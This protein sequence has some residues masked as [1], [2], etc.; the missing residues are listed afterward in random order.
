MAV[1]VFPTSPS[2]GDLYPSAPLAGQNQYVWEATTNTWRLVGVSTGVTPGTYGD[3]ENIPTFT[4]D[5]QGKITFASNNSIGDYYVKTGSTSAYNNYVWP[6]SDGAVNT[7]LTTDGSGNL[8]WTTVPLNNIPCSAITAKGDLITGAVPNVPA[9]LTV[10]SNGQLLTACSACAL[11]I[12]WS[13]P[14]TSSYIP[15]SA[16]F[17]KGSLLA[18]NGPAFPVSLLP[19]V[20][21]QVLVSC[22]GCYAGLTWTD[23]VLVPGNIS[24]S[25]ISGKGAILTGT[26]P[27]QPVALPVGPNGFAL[28]ACSAC[29]TGLNWVLPCQGTMTEIDTGYGLM[30]GPLTT[31]GTISLCAT[32][33]INPNILA[34]KGSLLVATAANTP[35]SL[36]VGTDGQLLTA[37]STNPKGIAWSTVSY[38]YIFCSAITAKGDILTGS[39]PNNPIALSVGSDGYVLRACSACTSGLQWGPVSSLGTAMMVPV[40]SQQIDPGAYGQIAVNSSYIYWY[41]GS[42]WQRAAKD[43]IPW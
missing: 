26:A 17:G 41:D 11:G 32:C 16:I 15:C 7:A 28:Q 12:Y 33:V 21:G 31:T 30:G 43:P 36:P 4:V 5:L 34:G 3:A 19:G 13:T 6:L 18:G 29:S 42:N 2:N 14:V 9:A 10:G 38:P 20:D 37:C 22:T 40:P 8:S 35:S 39:S 23:S 27:S 24:C 1:L 25:C